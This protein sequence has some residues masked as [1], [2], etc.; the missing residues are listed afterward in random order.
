MGTSCAVGF[1]I[2][3]PQ[4]QIIRPCSYNL[5]QNYVVLRNL[6]SIYIY[7]DPI[8]QLKFHCVVFTCGISQKVLLKLWYENPEIQE[9]KC[10]N[11]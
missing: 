10:Q 7:R 5:Y 4:M 8:S 6:L 1:P 9:D 11:Q 3:M 2:S